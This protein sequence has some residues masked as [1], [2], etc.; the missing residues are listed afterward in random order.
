MG[1]LLG[2]LRNKNGSVLFLVVMVMSLLI[3]A[4][5]ATFYIVN[6]QQSSVIVRYN[7]EQ[8][9]QTAKSMSGAVSQYING[10]LNAI[11]A[12][13]EKE[14]GKYS[15]TVVG[16]M[17]Q[18]ETITTKDLDLSA[19]GLNDS[20]SVSL[21]ITIK[22]S[23]SKK[24]KDNTVNF[25][26]IEVKSEC[27]G[28]TTTI[29]QVIA[30]ETGP[31]EYFTRF[32]TS[33]GKRSEDVIVSAFQILS[34]AY[35]EN[36][37]TRLSGAHMNDSVYVTGTFDDDGVI[38]HRSV[39]GSQTDIVVND[40]FYCKGAAGAVVDVNEIYVGG[41]F[42]CGKQI[43]ADKVYVLGDYTCNMSQGS[44][45]SVFYI[46]GDCYLNSGTTN[47]TDYQKFYINGDLYINNKSESQGEFHV[48]G[49]VIIPG[50]DMTLTTKGIECGGK[51]LY[52]DGTEVKPTDGSTG[53]W[54]TGESNWYKNWKFTHN[55]SYI[56][57]FDKDKVADVSNHIANKTAKNK[58]GTWDAEGYFNKNFPDAETIKPSDPKYS[59]GAWDSYTVTINK[60]CKLQPADWSWGKHYIIIDA[61]EKDI[62]IYLDN[63]G[64][65]KDGR[66]YFSF[67]NNTE[68]DAP[69][70]IVV[71]GTH[72]AIFV[73]P[74]NTDFRIGSSAFVGHIGFAKYMTGASSDDELIKGSNIRDSFKPTDE[75]VEKIQNLF[76]AGENDSTVIDRTKLSDKQTHNNIFLVTSD[77]SNWID[78]GGEATFCGY[79]Y[80]PSSVM[81]CDE[82]GQTIGFVGGLIMGSYTYENMNATLAFTTPYDYDGNYGVTKKTDIVKALMSISSTGSAEGAGNEFKDSYVVGY[83]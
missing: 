5:S 56:S 34:G 41:N 75:N 17:L 49:N 47:A 3:I 59:T 11:K 39:N 28:E 72:S 10:Y 53:W 22:P 73:L 46:D 23:G 54:E 24:D 57:L 13:G 12:S 80:A 83:K 20:D 67:N 25:F 61:S 15:N 44:S 63:N 69:V 76:I 79:I 19:L 9:Y 31:A 62:Y 52:A 37:F 50:Q 71:K 8:S 58:Y 40:N 38:Y 81:R 78:I 77:N 60:S 14:V 27:N 18:G 48:K 65:K 7:S 16:K 36:D 66:D 64:L 32:L 6:N 68:G 33:T 55:D 82:A 21:N 1:R 35:F 4:A 29:T 74:K 30:I 45:N 70:N 26:E 2:K 43:L 51:F 42:L